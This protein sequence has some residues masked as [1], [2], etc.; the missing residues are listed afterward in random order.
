MCCRHGSTVLLL[1]NVRTSVHVI[2][3]DCKSEYHAHVCVASVIECLKVMLGTAMVDLGGSFY[4]VRTLLFGVYKPLLPSEMHALCGHELTIEP[5]DMT[6]L[7][8]CSVWLQI[9]YQ[10][11]KKRGLIC[12]IPVFRSFLFLC[13]AIFSDIIQNP[14]S[15]SLCSVYAVCATIR[16]GDRVFF[17]AWLFEYPIP[18]WWPLNNLFSFSTGYLVDQKNMVTPVS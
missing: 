13:L 9:V 12:V 16:E 14:K 4:L 5:A 2:L 17:S 11:N 18:S 15:A 1:Q 10:N 8:P 7:S 3:A 6:S